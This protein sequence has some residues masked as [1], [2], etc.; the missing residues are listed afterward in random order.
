MGW[1]DGGHAL[2][3]AEDGRRQVS[4]LCDQLHSSG[5]SGALVSGIAPIHVS[6]PWRRFLR[7][8]FASIGTPAARTLRIQVQDRERPVVDTWRPAA[9]VEPAGLKSAP[10]AVATE[11]TVMLSHNGEMTKNSDLDRRSNLHQ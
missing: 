8:R 10:R 7:R 1:S 4:N 5:V 6:V 2:L 3:G 11:L 9:D